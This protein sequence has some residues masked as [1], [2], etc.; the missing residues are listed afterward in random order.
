MQFIF[1]SSSS[2]EKCSFILST[3]IWI[4]LT[5]FL[6]Y[7]K[8][9]HRHDISL[10]NWWLSMRVPKF[11]DIR[12]NSESRLS[13]LWISNDTT[14]I[15]VTISASFTCLCWL[16]PPCN[17]HNNHIRSICWGLWEIVIPRTGNPI[18]KAHREWVESRSFWGQS[19]RLLCN[20]SERRNSENGVKEH[21]WIQHMVN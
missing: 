5:T 10:R 15:E 6:L 19:F 7:M 13:K 14:P 12:V 17:S 4:E 8:P 2:S 11:W 9:M 1:V 20:G 16:L 18:S 21:K 3:A